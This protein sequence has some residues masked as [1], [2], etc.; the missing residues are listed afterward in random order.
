[1]DEDY[2]LKRLNELYSEGGNVITTGIKK[3]YPHVVDLT[4]TQ[5]D[6]GKF[7]KWKSKCITFLESILPAD[8]FRLMY[9]KE[10]MEHNYKYTAIEGNS[11]IESLIEDISENNFNLKKIT[12]TDPKQNLE[13]ILNNFHRVVRQLRNRHDNRQT[14]KI[15]DEYDVQDL[16]H[17]LLLIHFE[18]VRPEEWTP[19]YAGSSNRMDFLL[20]NE[21]IIIETKMTRPT[22]KDKKIGEELIIDI[23][24]YSQY[25]NCNVLYCFVYDP[26]EY[27]NNPKGLEN[28][29]SRK[30][31]ELEVNVII[32]PKF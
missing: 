14:I 29:L 32:V 1:M 4:P 15:T 5:V 21:N 22:L 28:D 20:K 6:T 17:A 18:D 9:F 27:I 11:I 23:E 24:K 30:Y 13:K 12:K 19:S 3:Q 8:D 26:Q 7:I 2:I 25:Q 31:E 16:L 10:D